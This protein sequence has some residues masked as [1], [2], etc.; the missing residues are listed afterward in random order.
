MK[1][2]VWPNGL[3]A[4]HGSHEIWWANPKSGLYGIRYF[5]RDGSYACLT[6]PGESTLTFPEMVQ[7]CKQYGQHIDW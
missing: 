7:A 1:T 4:D 3:G 6:I 2:R 5:Y